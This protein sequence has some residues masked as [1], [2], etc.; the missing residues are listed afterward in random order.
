MIGVYT[1]TNRVNGDMYVGSSNN[2]DRRIN[3]HKSYLR[4]NNHYNTKLQ[5]SV[6]KYNLSNFD[7][8]LLVECE[9]EH[10]FSTESYWYNILNPKYNLIEVNPN[11]G[12]NWSRQEKDCKRLESKTRI[13]V[14]CT[15]SKYLESDESYIFES[16][17]QAAK[18]LFPNEHPRVNT[19]SIAEVI[20]GKYS[21][22]N[23]WHFKRLDND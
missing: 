22:H 11:G 9:L 23:W 13:R 16:I 6:N 15:P 7:F 19:K 17:N 10:Q 12:R 1:I 4:N 14:L 8:E 2:V 18:T 21:H 5:N 3:A 20:K